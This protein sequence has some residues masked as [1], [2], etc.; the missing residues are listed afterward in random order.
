VYTSVAVL[1]FLIIL[2]VAPFAHKLHRTLTLL[3]ALVFTLGLVY[4]LFAAPFT[5]PAPMK[6][7]FAQ[8][9][10]LPPTQ[11]LLSGTEPY[12]FPLWQC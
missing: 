8:S 5:P 12:A 7:Y 9:L 10:E 1:A 4:T 2:P 11:P 6:V 3:V